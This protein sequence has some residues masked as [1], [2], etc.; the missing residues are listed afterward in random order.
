MT[1]DVELKSIKKSFN[2]QNI[3]KDFNLQV[4][5][6]EFISFLGPSGCGKTTTL[7]MLAGFLEP[8]EGELFIKGKKMNRIPPYHRELG[9]V[10]QTYSLFPHMTIFENV[11]YGLKLRK[12]PKTEIES[13]VKKVLELVQLPH[14]NDRFPNQLSGGQRQRIAIA[15]ALI[16]EPSILLLDEP[17]SNLD[18]KLRLELRDEL[19]RL[20]KQLGV[21]T[22]FVTHDQEEALSLSD[23][24]VVMSHGNIEQIGTP[25]E[26]YNQPKTEFVHTFIGQTN[27]F[28][29]TV[30]A[31]NG[32]EILI[33]SDDLCFNTR[34]QR[35]RFEPGDHISLFIRPESVYLSK[36]VHTD[37]NVTSMT[38]TIK[39]V[40]FL[41]AV[42]E[43]VIT[44]GNHNLTVRTQQPK[45]E[46][47]EGTIVSFYWDIH[48]QLLIKREE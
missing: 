27:R 17:L 16:T 33:S 34:S 2:N 14:L 40:T 26:I 6:G 37:P 35:K 3:V 29:G 45:S 20:H 43:Y 41:G 31:V 10:F 39:L 1:Y 24:I 30:E 22:I 11:A 19:K 42:T 48:D 47:V 5:K 8:N 13:R 12:V 46:W 36:D 32:D 7:N 21:T 9:M 25:D 15:R 4:K 23:R 28:Q 18:A 38:G 44:V